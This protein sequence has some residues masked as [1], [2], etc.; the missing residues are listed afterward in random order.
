MTKEEMKRKV[1]SDL[2]KRSAESVKE[3]NG[4]GYSE[5]MRRRALVRWNKAKVS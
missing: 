4:E 2:G 1:M 5:E 3:K